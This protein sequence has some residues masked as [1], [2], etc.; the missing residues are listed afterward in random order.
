MGK[1]FFRHE[2][3]AVFVFA[4]AG[5]RSNVN[6]KEAIGGVLVFGAGTQTQR[7]R[8]SGESQVSR[9]AASV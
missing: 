4:L 5:S 9:M 7:I 1:F 2:E 8:P 6:R 3:V